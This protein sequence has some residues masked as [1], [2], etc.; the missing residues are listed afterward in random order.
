MEIVNTMT[1]SVKE[2]VKEI[3]TM[4]AIGAKSKDIMFLFMFEAMYTGVIGGLLGA[5]LGFGL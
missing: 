2:W 3:G 5:G 4:K 1:V